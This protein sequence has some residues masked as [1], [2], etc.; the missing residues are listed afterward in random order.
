MPIIKGL[1]PYRYIYLSDCSRTRL[2][3]R[4]LLIGVS[5]HLNQNRFLRPERV[6]IFTPSQLITI[7]ITLFTL[8]F[9]YD[10]KDSIF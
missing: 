1:K 3:R 6:L 9:G 8:V 7:P 10:F 4:L 5:Y 2:F